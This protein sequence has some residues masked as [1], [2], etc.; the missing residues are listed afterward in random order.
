MKHTI[1]IFIVLSYL[2]LGAC[3]YSMNDTASSKW[4]AFGFLN[5]VVAI[6]GGIVKLELI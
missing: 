2:S 3:I 5:A 1:R 4:G 6:L